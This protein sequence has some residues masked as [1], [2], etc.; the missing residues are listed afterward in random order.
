MGCKAQVQS[1]CAGASGGAVVSADGCLV[2]LVT[3]NARHT[4]TGATLPNLNFC[5]AADALRPLWSALAAPPEGAGDALGATLARLD[6]S[7]SALSS[8]WALASQEGPQGQGCEEEAAG[9]RLHRLLR[10]KGVV[11]EAEGGP[12]ALSRL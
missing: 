1:T 10:E 8:M 3:S 5:L 9:A 4:S 7:D 12:V 11:G 6:V 2:G